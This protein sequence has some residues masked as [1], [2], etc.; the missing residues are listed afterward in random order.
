MLALPFVLFVED[1]AVARI[2]H[3]LRRRDDRG[4]AA[5]DSGYAAGES[6]KS[7]EHNQA[8]HYETRCIYLRVDII[9]GCISIRRLWR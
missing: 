4:F 6:T 9:W 2:V 7:L 8:L 3:R 1:L 5:V